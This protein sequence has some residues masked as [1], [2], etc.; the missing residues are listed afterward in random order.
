VVNYNEV[1]FNS[2]VNDVTPTTI[3]F[4]VNDYGHA[5]FVISRN[6]FHGFGYSQGTGTRACKILN[7]KNIVLLAHKWPSF[8]RTSTC[9]GFTTKMR[10]CH[11]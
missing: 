8:C 6:R 10:S 3:D 2:A 4:T 5:R 11:M 1:R 7:N 9:F